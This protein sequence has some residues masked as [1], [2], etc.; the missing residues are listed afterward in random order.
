M[1]FDVKH[2]V[3][4]SLM[5]ASLSACDST[6]EPIG[7]LEDTD[8]SLIL[9]EA[10]EYD[11]LDVR[12]QA[13]SWYLVTVEDNPG[14]T[15][16][17]DSEHATSASSGAYL[18]ALPDTFVREGDPSVIFEP[19]MGATLHYRAVFREAGI[20]YVWVRAYESGGGKDNTI[21]VG[22]DGTWPETGQRLQVCGLDAWI[23]SSNQ[24]GSEGTVCGVPLS[25]SL[26]VDEPGEHTVWFSM[27][28]DGFEFDRWL[29][30][31][32]ATLD[33]NTAIP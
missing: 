13:V 10:E 6:L 16:D 22:I 18:E 17:P 5:V 25:I 7:S 29:M 1:C 2:L 23:W 19:G 9:M 12:G 28:E 4:V 20:Y 26:L 31:R 11:A 3:S 32:D 8:S 24:R 21:H 15:P 30:T 27:R 33:P 14:V